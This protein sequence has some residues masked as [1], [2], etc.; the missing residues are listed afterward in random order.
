MTE[1]IRDKFKVV[2]TELGELSEVIRVM[3]LGLMNG[4][5]EMEYVLD[6]I[7][8]TESGLNVYQ[9]RIL[10]LLDNV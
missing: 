6:C 5:L 7:L 8:Y 3:R 9:D 1:E 4:D 2:A 10:Q